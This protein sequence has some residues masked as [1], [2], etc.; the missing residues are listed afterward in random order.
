MGLAT[1]V[2]GPYE[3]HELLVLAGGAGFLV[4]LQRGGCYLVSDDELTSGRYI[5]VRVVEFEVGQMR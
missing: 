4:M 2:V 5:I 3:L 1:A